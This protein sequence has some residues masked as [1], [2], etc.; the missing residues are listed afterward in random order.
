MDLPPPS[1]GEEKYSSYSSLFWSRAAK[2]Y[3]TIVPVVG[4]YIPSRF[5]VYLR[6]ESLQ[7]GLDP[8][9]KD[10]EFTPTGDVDGT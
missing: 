10:S 8:L 7:L 6:R 3:A 4:P 5:L 1:G 2:V 9:H